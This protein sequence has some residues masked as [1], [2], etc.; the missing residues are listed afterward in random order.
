MSES[1]GLFYIKCFKPFRNPTPLTQETEDEIL[2]DLRWEILEDGAL[3]AMNLG[4]KLKMVTVPEETR[5]KFW[6]K[7]RNEYYSDVKVVRDEL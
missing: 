1:T 5:F 7:L 2:G 4:K 3:R 6:D